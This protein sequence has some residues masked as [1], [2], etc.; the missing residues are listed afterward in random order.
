MKNSC[1]GCISHSISR[2]SR[3]GR[4]LV[5][6]PPFRVCNGVALVSLMLL[7]MCIPAPA[8]TRTWVGLGSDGLW[9][10]AANWSGSTL[11]AGTDDVIFA[12]SAVQK[13]TVNNLV[14]SLHSITFGG[15][16]FSISGNTLSL[17]NGINTTNTTGANT[18]VPPLILGANQSFTNLNPGTQLGFIVLDLDGHGLTF[19]G[20]GTN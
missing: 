4:N 20:A 12:S 19:R 16:G 1:V 15:G 8:A 2:V 9:T 14:T 6:C 17:T 13:G 11:P 3:P 10:T 5:W 18:F 7:L